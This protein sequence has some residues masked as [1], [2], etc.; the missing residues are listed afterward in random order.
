MATKTNI[1]SLDNLEVF[2]RPGAEVKKREDR[3]HA[4]CWVKLN[5]YTVSIQWG[6][7]NYSDNYDR[8][9]DTKPGDSKTAEVAIWKGTFNDGGDLIKWGAG[10]DTY[11][12]TVLGYV[13]M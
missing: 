12:E 11:G 3:F 6:N 5:G 1:F 2:E 7:G 10:D 4:G 13:P 9:L 8:D